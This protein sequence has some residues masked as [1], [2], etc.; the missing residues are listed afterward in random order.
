MITGSIVRRAALALVLSLGGVAAAQADEPI[1][2]YVYTTD[3]LPKGQKEVE[4]WAT[5]REGRSQGDFHLLQ[6]RTEVSYGLTDKLQLSGYLNLA[7]AD[8]LHD[9]PS[10][11]TAPPEVFADYRVDPASRYKKFRV[12]SVSAEAFYRV[13]SPYTSPVGLA[14]YFEP[15]IGPRTK[16]LEA[17]VI[18]QK[19]F[20]DDRLIFAANATL[21]YEWR[22]LHGDPTADPLSEDFVDHWDKETDV[23]FGLA[24][25]YRFASNWS[26][27]AEL[28]NEHEWA[29]LNPFDG[30]NKTN[31]AWYTGPTLHY[32]GRH[33]FATATVLFQLPWAADYADDPADSFVVHGITNGDDFEKYRFRFKVGYYF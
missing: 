23:N 2:G 13:L 12:E 32:A 1:F 15:S 26:A 22:K 30:A 28:Q 10:G 14:V 3:L 17:R 8:V 27:G 6:T 31:L 25:S 24:G 29:G 9:T 19:N 4:Q 33:M 20:M 16:E 7:Y 21:G 11:D 5:L 18:L